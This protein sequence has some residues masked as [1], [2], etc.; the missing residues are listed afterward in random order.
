MAEYVVLDF[1]TANPKRVSPSTSPT[2]AA[3]WAV[4]LMR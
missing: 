1:E 4:H 2:T 3:A